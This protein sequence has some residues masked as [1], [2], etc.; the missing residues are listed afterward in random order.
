MG[1]S[2]GRP[3]RSMDTGGPLED[4]L[5]WTPLE[6]LPPLRWQRRQDHFDHHAGLLQRELEDEAEQLTERQRRWS[7]R[8][9]EESGLALFGVE[10][11][12]NGWLYG[13][14]ILSF[15]RA[16]GDELPFHRFGQGDIAD[17]IQFRQKDGSA[18]EKFEMAR[19]VAVVCMACDAQLVVDDYLDLALAVG[20][21]GV[22]LGEE[23]L[24][25]E[26][27]RA[28][29]DRQSGR[30]RLIGAT[31]TTDDQAR[32]AQAAGVDYIG[33]GPVFATTSKANPASVKGLDGLA[34]ACRAVSIPV[35]AIG[36]ITLESIPSTLEAGAHGVAVMSAVVTAQDP[37]QVVLKLREA[38]DRYPAA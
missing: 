14:R 34:T 23:D 1:G 9:L 24:P 25:P 31:C 17:V 38:I 37:T 8:R 2:R 6:S 5:T 18:R 11:R 12:T 27:A 21:H 32:M 15:T 29:L 16:D 10:G 4:G 30:T 3:P 7:D 33:F 13:Q 19:R 35:I 22:H 28:V 20:A 36:G 26:T